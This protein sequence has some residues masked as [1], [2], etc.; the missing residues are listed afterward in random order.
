MMLVELVNAATSHVGITVYISFL[1]NLCAPERSAKDITLNIWMS[2]ERNLMEH[3]GVAEQ[4]LVSN[5][6]ILGKNISSSLLAKIVYLSLHPTCFHP[7]VQ[8]VNTK[9][10][11]WILTAEPWRS[12]CVVQCVLLHRE[13]LRSCTKELKLCT[14]LQSGSFIQCHVQEFIRL[15]CKSYCSDLASRQLTLFSYLLMGREQAKC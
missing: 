6:Y 11:T 15:Y 1:T 8:T 5:A 10:F 7:E 9:H 12:T 13:N 2:V 14:L 4:W 3:G